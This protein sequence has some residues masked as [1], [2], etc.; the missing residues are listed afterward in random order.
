MTLGLNGSRNNRGWL[1]DGETLRIIMKSPVSTK[2]LRQ[3]R[4]EQ[5]TATHHSN[6]PRR[7]QQSDHYG[8]IAYVNRPYTF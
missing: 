4:A 7:S 6:D 5:T 1:V 2:N 3:S 8:P